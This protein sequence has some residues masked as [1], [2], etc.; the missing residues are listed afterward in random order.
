MVRVAAFQKNYGS[1]DALLERSGLMPAQIAAT[2]E[3]H[4]GEQRKR[5]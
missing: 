3:T 1:Q 5:A 4:V 2:V